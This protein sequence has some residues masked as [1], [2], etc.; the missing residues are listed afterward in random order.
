[1]GNSEKSASHP[2]GYRRKTQNM[3]KSG[4]QEYDS[5]QRNTLSSNHSEEKLYN[6]DIVR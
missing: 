2:E 6:Y 4:K 1:M 5:S 3:L